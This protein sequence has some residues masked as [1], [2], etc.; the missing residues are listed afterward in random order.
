VWSLTDYLIR[1]KP[2][3][4]AAFNDK[5]HGRMNKQNFADNSDMVDFH[6]SAFQEVFGMNYIEFEAAWMKWVEETYVAPPP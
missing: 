6:R 2:K 5:L 3:E 1:A 4:Y